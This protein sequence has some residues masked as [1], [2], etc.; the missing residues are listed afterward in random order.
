MGKISDLASNEMPFHSNPWLLTN[1]PAGTSQGFI[2][3]VVATTRS[4]ACLFVGAELSFM[5][6]QL[7]FMGGGARS[8]AMHVVRGWG[9]DSCAGC[10]G[11]LGCR[12]WAQW[13]CVGVVWSPLA[14]S[15]G[16]KVDGVLT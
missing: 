11:V 14:R 3:K 2:I 12:L 7:S 16:T 13:C 10:S 15:D 9:A 5:G 6:A 4:W 1:A 8:R